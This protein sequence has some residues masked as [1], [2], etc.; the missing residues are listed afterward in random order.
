MMKAKFTHREQDDGTW[1]SIC[2]LCYRTA[3]ESEAEVELRKA[4]LL[5]DCGAS[6]RSQDCVQVS[7][8]LPAD[9]R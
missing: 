2:M 3:A 7:D 9:T 5:H 4:E 1:A 6:K 8:F